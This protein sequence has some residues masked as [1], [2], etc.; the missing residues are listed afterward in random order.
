MRANE[1]IYY[2]SKG[3]YATE[4][5]TEVAIETIMKHDTKQPMFMLLNQ[6]AAHAGN[7]DDP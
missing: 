5:F 3:K 4:L 6:L 2:E 1:S 7:E